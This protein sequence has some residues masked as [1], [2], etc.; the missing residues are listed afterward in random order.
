MRVR[1]VLA[2]EAG[3]LREIR[4]RSLHTDPYAYDSTYEGDLAKPPD[5]WERGAR[6]SEQGE[7]R[8]YVVVDQEDDRW[9]G[10]ALVR[11]DDESL[12]DAVINAMW[13]AP[14]IRGRG[15]SRLLL[16][17]CVAWARE[18]RFRAVNLA[19]YT[20]NIPAYRAYEAAGFVAVC[21]EHDETFL[22]RRLCDS[23]HV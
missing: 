19:V 17:A 10:M 18:R 1:H 23:K 12:G 14:E 21:K 13:V 8:I 7:Q 6:R 11:P 4:L 22:S 16:D 2:H 5:W 9:H 3:R 20:T 15:A